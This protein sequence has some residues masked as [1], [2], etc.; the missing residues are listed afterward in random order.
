MQNVLFHYLWGISTRSNPQ[1]CLHPNL[2]TRRNAPALILSQPDLFTVNQHCTHTSFLLTRRLPP[3]PLSTLDHP[4]E[5]QSG[6]INQLA[7]LNIWRK[8]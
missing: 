4:A 5:Y 8:S 1:R 2:V 6:F 7:I 3:S